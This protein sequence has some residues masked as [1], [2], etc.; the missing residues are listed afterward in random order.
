MTGL[1][2]PSKLLADNNE[3]WVTAPGLKPGYILVGVNTRTLTHHQ[4]KVE[5]RKN[6]VKVDYILTG[7]E[8]KPWV[9]IVYKKQLNC[10]R[11]RDRFRPLSEDEW[12]DWT[13]IKEDAYTEIAREKACQSK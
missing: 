5:K 11:N 13:L 6:C 1:I 3:E 10:K 2:T 12:R 4:L 7:F 9:V 8:R